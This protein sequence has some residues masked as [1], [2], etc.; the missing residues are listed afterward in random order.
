MKNNT[1]FF[2]IDFLF[3]CYAPIGRNTPI[4][5]N[6]S[7]LVAVTIRKTTLVGT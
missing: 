5:F 7:I 1:P 3:L 2:L 6:I 4:K